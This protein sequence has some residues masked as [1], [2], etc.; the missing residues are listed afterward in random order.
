M[1]TSIPPGQKQCISI[2]QTECKQTRASLGVG[3]L[4]R[5]WPTPQDFEKLVS[6]NDHFRKFQKNWFLVAPKVSNLKEGPAEWQTSDISK[7]LGTYNS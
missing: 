2:E 6:K 1:C 5:P 4:G 3:P 7:Y